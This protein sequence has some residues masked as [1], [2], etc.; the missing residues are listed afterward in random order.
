MEHFMDTVKNNAPAAVPAVQEISVM[1]AA[2]IAPAISQA[3]QVYAAINAVQREIA[4]TGISKSNTT[5]G[6]A[7]FKFRG[8]DDV[9]NALSP[10]MAKHDLIVAPRYSDRALIERKSSNGNA[11]FY[12]TITGNFDFISVKDGSKHTVTTFGEAMDSGDKGTNKAMAI[13][14]KYALLQV[15]AIPTEGDNDPDNYTHNPQPYQS[16]NQEQ[17]NN[18]THVGQ[19]QRMNT[20]PLRMAVLQFATPETIAG[21]PKTSDGRRLFSPEQ[22][23]DLELSILNKQFK[24]SDFLNP[25][26]YYFSD[27]Q[28]AILNNLNNGQLM[29][30]Q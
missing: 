24:A 28:F 26:K 12:I 4:I 16:N 8:I 19:A 13:A 11:L 9:Y 18:Q 6:G 25:D 2:A 21:K 1:Q 30:G 7:K 20:P 15:F 22:F 27:E 10:L 14:H 3:P 5:T 29:I 17:N 23:R